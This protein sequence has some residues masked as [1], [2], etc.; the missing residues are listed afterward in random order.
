MSHRKQFQVSTGRAGAGYL[1]PSSP[2]ETLS[3]IPPGE[4]SSAS[5]AI[6]VLHR[7]PLAS[8]NVKIWFSKSLRCR[9]KVCS[10]SIFI[11]KYSPNKFKLCGRPLPAAYLSVRLNSKIQNWY[12]PSIQR[13]L[14]SGKT[15][16]VEIEMLNVNFQFVFCKQRIAEFQISK[17]DFH[18]WVDSTILVFEYLSILFEFSQFQSLK[19]GSQ[20]CN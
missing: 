20:I 1:V 11:M 13:F 5:S 9:H 2:L 17:L 15:N 8:Q 4:T 19:I 12:Q 6:S 18:E 16:V 14:S 7:S 3:I 10:P